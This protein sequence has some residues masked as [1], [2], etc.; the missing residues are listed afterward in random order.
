M[1][2]TILKGEKHHKKNKLQLKKYQ[3]PNNLNTKQNLVF[4]KQLKNSQKVVKN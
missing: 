2:K 1:G 4:L 3:E